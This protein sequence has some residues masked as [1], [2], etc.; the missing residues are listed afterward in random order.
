[1]LGP[2]GARVRIRDWMLATVPGRLDVVRQRLDT[3]WPPDPKRIELIDLLSPDA[4]FESGA[5]PLVLIS[6][7]ELEKITKHGSGPN[8]GSTFI[9]CYPVTVGIMVDSDSYGDYEQACVG[10]DRTL[11]AIRE[12]LFSDAVITRDGDDIVAW[13]DLAEYSEATGPLKPS[14]LATTLQ[15]RLLAAA[16]IKFSIEQL[17]TLDGDFVPVESTDVEIDPLT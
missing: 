6:T 3:Q 1:M 7:H 11:L 2:E 5:F 15:G 16:E 4:A 17:E 13:A 12:Q 10:R 14:P 9:C 8:V